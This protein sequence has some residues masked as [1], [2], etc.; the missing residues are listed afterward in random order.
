LKKLAER[1]APAAPVKGRAVLPPLEYHH[2]YE[3]KLTIIEAR[4][5][6]DASRLPEN[7]TSKLPSVALAIP[8][9]MSVALFSRLSRL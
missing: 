5:G 6:R 9:S 7:S 2:P 8:L 1:M 3:G 4:Q